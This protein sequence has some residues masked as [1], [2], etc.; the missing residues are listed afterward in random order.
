MRTRAALIDR[1]EQSA[2]S[3]AQAT[4]AAIDH[5]N[6]EHLA[7]T[8][9]VA[10]MPI[11]V[12][13]VTNPQTDR[14][15][16]DALLASYKATSPTVT[17][18]FLLDSSG[19]AIA[20]TDP[21]M[22]GKN[23]DF[24]PYW[25]RGIKGEVN[26]SP[27]SVSVDTK[28][29]QIVY[30]APIRQNGAIV[31]VTAYRTDAS[32]VFAL[33]NG[34]TDAEGTGT[35]GLLVD[36]H[37][38]RLF[39]AADPAAQFTAIV[40]P[41]LDVEKQILSEKQFGDKTTLDATDDQTL[42]GGLRNAA[43]TPFFTISQNGVPAFAAAA[44]LTSQTWTY[45]LRVPERTFLSA[46]N[47]ISM[48]A[49]IIGIV[50]ALLTAV[51]GVVLARSIAVPLR[52]LTNLGDHVACG[53]VDYELSDAEHRKTIRR[54]EIGQ[55]AST[56]SNVRR[57]LMDLARAAEKIASGD[58]TVTVNAQSE[59]DVLGTAFAR[60][61]VDLRLLVGD[62]HRSAL[63]L[64]ET[65][66]QLGAASDQ[67]SSAVQQVTQAV[68]NVADGAQNSSRD[69]QETNAAVE[70]LGRSI[71]H[72]ARGTTQQARQVE[73]TNATAVQMSA[74]VESV[75]ASAT[76]VAEHGQQ[77]RAA[78][79][80]GAEAVE[81]TVTEMG[82]I[83]TVVNQA[84]VKVQEL[85]KLGERIGQVVETIDDIAAQT[86]LLALNAAIEAAR[87]GEHG[88]G[89]AVVADE[90]RKLAERSGRETKAIAELI[91]QVQGGTRDAVG[92][93]AAGAAK[94]EQGSLRAD[95]AG[96]A[97]HDILVAVE[98]SVRQAGDIAVS[99]QEMAS[100]SRNVVEAMSSM[101]AVVQE[102]NAAAD[103]MSAQ[104]ERVAGAITS[105]AAVAEEQSAA[106]E[107][108]SASTEEMSAQVEQMSAQAQEL[109]ATAETLRGLVVRFTI[110]R[111]ASQSVPAL[112]GP[113]GSLRLAA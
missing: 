67:T 38:V 104:A 29:P 43:K 28:K 50:A 36:D 6:A 35:T 39:D 1:A 85:G 73:I 49:V 93:M 83:R 68:Q 20:S 18:V 41:A 74:G 65:S 99:A 10:A 44:P 9:V 98:A 79:Q 16:V 12:D 88:K 21:T 47:D 27:L 31:G 63:T 94:V 90:V 58:L 72:I 30:S 86:N 55:I 17:G 112:A 97:L 8:T 66:A 78:A 14:A 15:E 61:T 42:L 51:F 113:A 37:G 45:A 92:A 109:A 22:V 19:N 64:A 46:A 56:F 100:A 110:D 75:A 24:R 59:R 101:S 103:E 95:S 84:M 13:A 11:S 3:K 4:A 106:T 80:R 53:E 54:D 87:A 57:Y 82:D 5:L 71:A 96:R 81:Q 105:I 7:M 52:I 26:A 40:R 33:I 62:V 32:D 34:D 2:V 70:L 48:G 102:S 89:F 107:E 69:A 76:E 60:M 77:T 111:Q 25:Q 91:E 23:Y 108:V